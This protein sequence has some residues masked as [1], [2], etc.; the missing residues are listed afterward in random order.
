MLARIVAG[1]L[2]CLAGAAAPAGLAHGRTLTA[3]DYARAERFMPYN[4]APLVDHA[5]ERVALAG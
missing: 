4:S 5:V 3:Q 1:A 2:G